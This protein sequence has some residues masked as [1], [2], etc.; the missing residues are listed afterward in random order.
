VSVKGAA[1]ACEQEKVMTKTNR[2]YKKKWGRK[3][4][5]CEKATSLIGAYVQSNLSPQMS[6]LFEEHLRACPDCVSF[7]NTYR[8]TLELAKSF[9]AADAP[10]E[11]PARIRS[12]ILDE[13][14]GP[15]AT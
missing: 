9:L 2:V 1:R 5:T 6:L 15:K 10:A 12:R 14:E 3:Q 11:S 8:K 4:I 7:L 13:R